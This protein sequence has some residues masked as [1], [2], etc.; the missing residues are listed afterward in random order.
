MCG[1]EA[2]RWLGDDI[3]LRD[4]AVRAAVGVGP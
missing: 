1:P 4:P 2:D 3:S